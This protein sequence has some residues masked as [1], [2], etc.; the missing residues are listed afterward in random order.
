MVMRA[1]SA[2][3]PANAYF[4]VFDFHWYFFY[5]GITRYSDTN[6]S[7]DQTLHSRSAKS[8]V[9]IIVSICQGVAFVQKLQLL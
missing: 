4:R 8:L 5:P 9:I 1:K 2:G 3:K 6:E 7:V